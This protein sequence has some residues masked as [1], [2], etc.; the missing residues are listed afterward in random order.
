MSETRYSH[1]RIV[2]LLD[3]IGHFAAGKNTVIMSHYCSLWIVFVIG[4]LM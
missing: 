1:R 2:G 3:F 4:L